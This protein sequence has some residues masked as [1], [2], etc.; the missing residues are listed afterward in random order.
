MLYRPRVQTTTYV[1]WLAPALLLTLALGTVFFIVRRR[2][3][4]PTPRNPALN[5]DEQAALQALLTST[6]LTGTDKQSLSEPD[7][8]T[9]QKVNE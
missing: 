6:E 8:T 3:V 1:L 4:A 5:A 9:T 7:Q 2:R